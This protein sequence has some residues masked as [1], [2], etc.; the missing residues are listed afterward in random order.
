MA[1]TFMA[2]S[3]EREGN[4]C[5]IHLSACAAPTARSVMAGDG[6]RHV[7]RSGEHVRRRPARAHAR[8]HPAPR[9][10]TST[11]TSATS[12][13]SFAPTAL[14]WGRD[15]R[16]C[17]LRLVGHGAVAAAGEPRARAATST[18]TWPSPRWSPP[19]WHGIEQRAGAR[20]GVRRAT[21]TTTRTPSTC[22]TTLREAAGPVGGQ[23]V[24][25]RDV[26]RRR[27]RPLRQHGRGRAGRLRRGG[28]RL[29]AHPGVR[30]PVSELRSTLHDVVNPATEEVV[31]TRRRSPDVARDRRRRSPR[32]RARLPRAGGTVAPG[33]PRPAAAPVRRR[34]STR[35][36]R[37]WPSS[38]CATP[39]TRSATP[40]GRPA[41]SATSSTTTAR[42]AGAA[43]RPADP[44][45]RRRRRH[46][47][48]AARRRRR[49]RAVELPDAD[50]RLGL[51]ARRWPPATPSC[52]S[53]PS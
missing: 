52:S 22:P 45:R 24:R 34:W 31:T 51:R 40:A 41:T 17:A 48:R 23:R 32:A 15:N 1:L 12:S 9:A 43:V 42:R 47:P 26:R 44:G 21:P 16:T 4:S 39:G 20:A 35:T 30:A 50:R 49:H 3:D 5:H 38:R 46:V 33:R 36:S 8:A 10:R 6:A 7:R 27:G 37:S 14:R 29:G 28:H 25:P 13:G 11:P 53:R 18:R 19:G 2:K